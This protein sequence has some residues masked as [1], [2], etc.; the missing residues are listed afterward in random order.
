MLGEFWRRVWY[1]LNRARFE[2]ALEAEIAAHRD[3][4]R[5]PR[6]FGNPLALREQ[7]R[8]VWGWGWLDRAI[9]DLR[10]GWRVIRRAPAFAATVVLFLALGIG[11]NLTFF[12]LL[13]VVALKPIGVS[14]PETLVRFLPRGPRSV[15]SGL[16]YPAARVV[17]DSN[18]VLSAVLLRRPSMVVWEDDEDGQLPA[19]FV[20]ANWF[21]ELGYGPAMGR[22]FSVPFDGGA[23][24]SPAVVVSHDFWRTRLVSDPGAIGRRVRVNNRPATIV[25]VAP[26]RLRD[27]E[28]GDP[29]VW[30]LIDQADYFEPGTRLESDWSSR[31][32]QLFGRLRAGISPEAAQEGLAPSMTILAERAPRMFSADHWLEPSTAADHFRRDRDRQEMWTAISLV[33]GLTLVVLAV[34]CANLSNVVLSRAIGRLR[35]LSVRSA[36]GASRWRILRQILVECGLL[37]AA[38]AA[39]G[40][41]IGYAAARVLGA[42]TELPPSLDFSPD[43]RLFTAA[44]GAAFVAMIVFGVIPAWIVSRSD[45][46]HA[47]KDGGDQVSSGLARTRLRILLVAVQVV[48]CCALLIVAGAIGRRLQQQLAADPGFSYE[49][50]AVVDAG[51]ARHGVD[52]D[53]ARAY[54]AMVTE[55]IGRHPDVAAVSIASPAPLGGAHSSTTHDT[56]AGRLLVAKLKVD[57]QFFSLLEI[58]LIA[59]RA[60]APGDDPSAVIISRRVAMAMYGTVNAIGQ[61][62]P[63]SRPS[64]TVIGVAE[65]TD[66]V[67]VTNPHGEEY[68]PLESGDH[69]SASL[70]VRSRSDP[71]R[72]I[73]PLRRAAT[74]ADARVMPSTRLLAQDYGRGMQGAKIASSIAAAVATLVLTLACL[75]VF[76][77]VSYGVRLRT[78]EI[79]IRRA[80][81][82]DATRVITVLLKQM[83][84]PTGLA[85]VVGSVAGIL[86]SRL[87]SGDPFYLAAGDAISSMTALIVF[88]VATLLAAVI[89]AMRALRLDPVRALRHE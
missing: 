69:A 28:L 8:D 75:G 7:S 36:L 79:G 56:G 27:F 25:G 30:L 45:L 86:V 40:I 20:S 68:A 17:R 42:V 76:G 89:P 1:R 5:E 24:A 55:A 64:Q 23:Q 52:R 58:P 62:Y 72:L 9:Q 78:K 15:S 37:T 51:L 71:R 46:I 49:S 16:S 10:D 73:V 83:V 31:D 32:V 65:D 18:T 80:L 74:D 63:T 12:Q 35:E 53:Q 57:G 39:A 84:W 61:G 6:R 59:G 33:G 81:G 44:I 87:L 88:A 29:R 21:D 54:W 26:P 66:I 19:V 77:V 85:A 43:W 2:R 34:A 41:A 67:R 3:Q 13:N 47:L 4:L 70:M 50:V 14:Q 82:A 48:G 11:L 22:L 38:G 60:F